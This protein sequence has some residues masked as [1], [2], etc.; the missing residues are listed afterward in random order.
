MNGLGGSHVT[1]QS[2][3]IRQLDNSTEIHELDNRY[4]E[5]LHS[6]EGPA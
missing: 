5:D 6:A 4:F 1:H 2:P 3:V